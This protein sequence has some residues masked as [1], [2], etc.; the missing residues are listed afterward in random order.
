MYPFLP[1]RSHSSV[2]VALD[3]A[4]SNSG[5]RVVTSS[6]RVSIGFCFGTN[7]LPIEKERRKRWWGKRRRRWFS[8]LNKWAGN[9]STSAQTEETGTCKPD[10]AF[11]TL[12]NLSKKKIK[13]NPTVNG[14][15]IMWLVILLQ[16]LALCHSHKTAWL[17]SVS[18][19][20]HAHSMDTFPDKA[21]V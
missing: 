13:K 12:R 15:S 4:S 16:P 11:E 8:P 18:V 21:A 17:P 1:A 3:R 2:S 20:L 9:T 5:S 14:W 19:C 10:D 6:L 7:A